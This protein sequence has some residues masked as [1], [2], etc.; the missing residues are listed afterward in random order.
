MTV[1]VRR[2][3]VLSVLVLLY[4]CPEPKKQ[5]EAR[6]DGSGLALEFAT[7]P[8][9][10]ADP[11]VL[12][13][14]EA[15][16][17]SVYVNAVNVFVSFDKRH[18]WKELNAT[19]LGYIQDWVFV[20]PTAGI[21]LTGKHGLAYIELDKDVIWYL[22]NE[23]AWS[24]WRL[25]DDGTL[26]TVR[27]AVTDPTSQRGDE[28]AQ[29]WLG[30]RRAFT[31]DAPWPEVQLPSLPFSYRTYQPSVHF[32]AGGEIY[33]ASYFG[34][35]VSRDDGQT[36]QQIPV[37]PNE[38]GSID[39][40]GVDLFVTRAG[41]LFARTPNTSF[42]SHDGG[43]TWVGAAFPGGIG[44]RDSMMTMEEPVPGELH[45]RDVAFRST[46]E[47]R[48]YQ[49]LFTLERYA[50]QHY[51]E[52]LFFRGG[53]YYFHL[54]LLSN[55]V[56]AAPDTSLGILNPHQGASVAPA[57]L[58]RAF[59][60]S[61]RSFLG[62]W[63]QGVIRYTAGD[64]EWKVERFFPNVRYLER[65]RGGTVAVAATEGLRFSRDEGVTWE[66]PVA[67]SKSWPN[68]VTVN[69]LTEAQGRLFVSGTDSASCERVLLESRDNGASWQLFNVAFVL[70]PQ[71]EPVTAVPQV[72]LSTSDHS[73]QL[74]GTVFDGS[75]CS[76]VRSFT[77][78]SD[79]MGRTWKGNAERLPLASTSRDSLLA[80]DDDASG[81]VILRWDRSSKEWL[82]FGPPKVDG[83]TVPNLFVGKPFIHVDADDH[84]YFVD[85]HR[86]LRS[87]L[88][89]E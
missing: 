6:P 54:G 30:R 29:V 71:Q 36:W 87:S 60:T 34:L 62:L 65:L 16:G 5:E 43:A 59:P 38:Q 78:S 86:V 45:F 51:L 77:A 52:T 84:V 42:V 8:V 68:S 21:A 63:N 70:D 74:F 69:V 10:G 20:T 83:A 4:G 27:Q 75:R 13:E 85:G 73:G 58:T 61:N 26:F 50:D 31:E 47:G 66:A 40:S 14:V 44:N 22:N 80:I 12:Q 57:N 7:P 3:A 1:S 81:E 23:P 28:T 41:T 82:P 48:S 53:E 2:V 17:D 33:V 15:M 19:A 89:V 79:D 32:G 55:F 18:T 46:D 11:R 64:P 37:M 88:A 25:R 39:W 56:S 9:E 24:A 72:E 49:Q 76:T 35:Q 67:I